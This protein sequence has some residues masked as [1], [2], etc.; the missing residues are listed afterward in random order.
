MRGRLRS[1]NIIDQLGIFISLDRNPEARNS[2]GCRGF[3]PD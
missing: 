2:V 1:I 3:D